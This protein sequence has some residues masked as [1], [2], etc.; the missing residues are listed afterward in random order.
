LGCRLGETSLDCSDRRLGR[1]ARSRCI[2]PGSHAARKAGYPV[3]TV[4]LRNFV[5]DS[6][7]LAKRCEDLQA[8]QEKWLAKQHRPD[9]RI[10]FDGTFGSLIAVY[11]TDE[12]SPYQQRPRSSRTPIHY[13]LRTLRRAVGERRLDH[14]NG[15]DFPRWYRAFRAPRK[16]G[17]RER[18]SNATQLIKRARAVLSFGVELGIADALRLRQVFSF[19]EF[20]APK[21]RTQQVEFQQASAFI[22]IAHE[23]GEHGLAMAQAFEFELMMRQTDVIGKYEDRKD[24]PNVLVSVNGLRWQEITEDRILVHSASKNDRGVAHDL[25]EYPLVRAELDRLPAVPRIGSV[26]VDHKTGRPFKYP[27][28]ARRWRNVARLAGIPDEV[29]NRDSRAGGITEARTAGADKDDVREAA[30]HAEAR[31]TD[32]YVRDKLEQTRRMARSRA[33]LRRGRKPVENNS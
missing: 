14:L 9:K 10:Q 11:E 8:E 15:I 24:L 29:W 28:F 20:E 4:R 1:T 12:E 33:A 5:D 26:I 22:A 21:S 7:Q 32:P 3:K 17:G 31:T 27:E 6:P 18:I 16:E 2:G 19:M 25:N 23:V 30:G 13:Q